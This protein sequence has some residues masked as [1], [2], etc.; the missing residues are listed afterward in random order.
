MGSSFG[1]KKFKGLCTYEETNCGRC[2][3]EFLVKLLG[4][5]FVYGLLSVNFIDLVLIGNTIPGYHLWLAFSYFSPFV[6]VLLIS[7]LEDWELVAGLGFVASLMN[8]LFYHPVGIA[9]LGNSVDLVKRYSF[10]F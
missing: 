1:F 3:K 10:Q 6:P 2:K 9:L 5:S 4:F 8:D 7:G